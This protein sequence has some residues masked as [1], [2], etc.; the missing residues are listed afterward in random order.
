MPKKKNRLFQILDADLSRSSP[1]L[2]SVHG[3]LI[4]CNKLN[5]LYGTSI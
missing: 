2:A 1:S 5:E 3:V 4:V